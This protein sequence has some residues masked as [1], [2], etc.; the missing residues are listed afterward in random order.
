MSNDAIPQ[1][2]KL[3]IFDPFIDDKG[4]Q[5]IKNRL[6]Y[7]VLNHDTKLPII[8]PIGTLTKLSIIYQLKFLKH[9]GVDTVISSLRT[10]FWIVGVT[11]L[12][13]Q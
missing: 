6:Q 2:S 13:R 10:N 8:I 12:V 5:R 4:L 11:R 3:S 1:G 9:A 7:S